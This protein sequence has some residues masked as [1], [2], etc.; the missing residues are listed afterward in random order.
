MP[1]PPSPFCHT[2]KYFWNRALRSAGISWSV[3]TA[4]MTY[5][6]VRMG[7]HWTSPTTHPA[8]FWIRE[9]C[10]NPRRTASRTVSSDTAPEGSVGGA[11]SAR[12]RGTDSG[13]GSAP[14]SAPGVNAMG[15]FDLSAVR[16]VV[17]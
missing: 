11:D 4:V 5:W 12:G 10:W 3:M 7:D 16:S 6:A 17:G 8:G 13:S 14:G 15:L 9:R 1:Q 2:S